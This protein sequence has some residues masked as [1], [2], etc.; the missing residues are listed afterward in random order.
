LRGG[1]LDGV[2]EFGEER[3]GDL[4][5]GEADGFAAAEAQTPGETI[6]AIVEGDHGVIDAFGRI[7]REHETAVEVT[8]DGRL[9]YV[10]Q[11]RDVADR[12]YFCHV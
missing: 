5:H 8:R 6:L 12:G 3:I 1:F 10:R 11:I 2:R 9:G 7:G 4:R